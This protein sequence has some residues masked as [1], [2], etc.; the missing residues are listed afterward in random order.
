MVDHGLAGR[1]MWDALKAQVM[2]RRNSMWILALT[3]FLGAGI[4]FV[5]HFWEVDSQ[6]EEDSAC[7]QVEKLTFASEGGMSVSTHT[8]VCTALATVI[9]T[10][11]YVHHSEVPPVPKDLVLRYSQAASVDHP[12]IHWI[13]KGRV[14]IEANHVAR[15]SKMEKLHGDVSIKYKLSSN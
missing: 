1:R 8:T 5:V 6:G 2:K 9:N 4:V 10:Y 15:I 11:V 13:D 12:K 14:L 3:L 7:T